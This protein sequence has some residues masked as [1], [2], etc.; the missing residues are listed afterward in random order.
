MNK[1]L[2][3]DIKASAPMA[4]HAVLN[5]QLQDG[6]NSLD[7]DDMMKNDLLAA[8][9]PDELEFLLPHLEAVHVEFDKQLFQYG[10][11]ITQVYFPTTAII[12]LMYLLADG[13]S[14]EI[15]VV[16]HDGLLGISALLG[17]TAIGTAM[18]QSAGYAYRLKVGVL[19]DACQ[20]YPRLQQLLMRYTQILFGQIAQ[21]SVCSRHYSLDQQLSHWLL[22][23][24]DRLPTNVLKMTQEMIA[25][26]LGVRRE[27]I[28]EAVGRLQ[29]QGLIQHRRGSITLL[30][31][32]GLEKYAGECYQATKHAFNLIMG[33]GVLR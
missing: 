1:S 31:R 32:V 3:S 19:K 18:V 16:G 14:S 11:K 6:K 20:R 25:G 8:M 5:R 23:R 24:L 7:A 12:A 22:N 13:G 26:M 21:N 30:N 29:Q 28:T 2:G 10:E 4:T 27:S 17:E 15:A 33:N 9:S